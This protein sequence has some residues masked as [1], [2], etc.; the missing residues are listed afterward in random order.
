MFPYDGY[1]R[2][3]KKLSTFVDNEACLRSAVSRAYYASLY[4]SIR[5]AEGK[6]ATFLCKGKSEIHREVVDYFKYNGDI[7]FD[8]VSAELGRLRKD[9]NNCD[10]DDNVK[11]IK[12]TAENAIIDAEA[13]FNKIVV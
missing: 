3:A 12:K 5:F 6:G 11:N 4:K 7:F 9:R 2:L 10:Y 8:L 1:L 13:I